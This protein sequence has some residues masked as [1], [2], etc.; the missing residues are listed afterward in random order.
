[1]QKLTSHLIEICCQNLNTDLCGWQYAPDKIEYDSLDDAITAASAWLNLNNI[2][3]A[4]VLEHD[5]VGD[6]VLIVWNRTK[7]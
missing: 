6:R 3:S 5:K 1:M 7:V 4:R 2:K